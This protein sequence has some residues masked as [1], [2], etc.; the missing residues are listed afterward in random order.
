MGPR[1]R[2]F[3]PSRRT[4]MSHARTRSAASAPRDLGRRRAHAPGARWAGGGAGKEEG[5]WGVRCLLSRQQWGTKAE[6]L[7]SSGSTPIGPRA[8]RD[9]EAKGANFARK[10][11][12]LRP[13]RPL[14]AKPGLG[15]AEM[16]GCG[17]VLAARQPLRIFSSSL[18]SAQRGNEVVPHLKAFI[19]ECPGGR[20]RLRGGQKRPPPP[21]GAYPGTPFRGMG[22]CQPLEQL[23]L[24]FEV[25]PCVPQAAGFQAFGASMWPLRRNPESRGQI[26]PYLL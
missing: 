1:S 16:S 26:A 2:P 15:P 11:R 6:L 24:T 18:V 22:L 17:L 12:P 19:Q 8:G 7:V 13:R 3:L 9:S 14:G 4:S 21:L 20:W 25:N 23:F 10:S 5:G